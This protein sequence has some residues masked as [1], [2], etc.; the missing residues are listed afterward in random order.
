MDSLPEYGEIPNACSSQA[1]VLRPVD[2]GD[3][4]YL[5]RTDR[6]IGWITREEQSV[7]RAS[8]VAIAGTGGMG[9][10]IAQSM[11]RLGIGE[12]RIA[13]PESFELSN[14]NRQVGAARSTIGRSKA[15]ETARSLRSITDDYRLVIYPQ[16]ICADSTEEFV[17]GADVI[18]DEIE[19]WNIGSCI[20]MHQ[21]ARGFGIPIFNCLSV[22]FATYLHLFTSDSKPVE[23]MLGLSLYEAEVLEHEVC[24]GTISTSDRKQFAEAILRCFIP[25]I[26]CYYSKEETL[27]NTLAKNRLV[28][29][30]TA[31]II[32]TNPLTSAGFV[33]TQA[34]LILLKSH[35]VQRAIPGLPVSPGYVFFDTAKLDMKMVY[36]EGTKR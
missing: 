9:G 26:P 24:D 22:G 31:S 35:G 17:R 12:I 2:R 23:S 32:A 10:L 20:R 8:C 13:D 34:L 36:A 1:F 16:G 11:V 25:E 29:N 27:Q 21:A 30:G 4:Y 33:A 14:M 6:N 5:E 28:L 3:A 18:I 19:F 7:L 15:V